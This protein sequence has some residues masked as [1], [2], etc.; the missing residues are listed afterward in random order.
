MK[1]T[2]ASEHQAAIEDIVQEHGESSRRRAEAG[3]AQV[4]CYWRTQDGDQ[5]AMAAFCRDHF[6]SDAHDCAR[7]L[8]RLETALGTT[9]G[10]LNEI[11]RDLRRWTDLRGDDMPGTDDILATFDPAPDLSEQY[12]A[13]KLAFIAMLN[14]ERPDLDTMLQ[15]GAD[16]DADRW[17]AVRVAKSFGPRIP[18]EIADEARAVGH[19]ANKWV[20]EF[21]VPVGN[22]VDEHG[23]S[24]FEP[25][26]KLLAHWLIREA[27][28]SLYG[29]P[30]GLPGQRALLHVMG[31]HID[32][33]IPRA[34]MDG[35]ASGPWDP[36]NNTIGSRQTNDFVGNTRYERWLEQFHLAQR[37][38]E[39][40]PEYP[41]ALARKFQWHRE[42]P[43]AEVESLLEQLLASPVRSQLAKLMESRLGR[44]LEAHDIYYE[45]LFESRP[46]DEM[47]ALVS[48][49][50]ADH[51]DFQAKLTTLL[52]ELGYPDEQAH[53]L[54]NNVQ[55]EIARGSGH[56][57]RP[58]MPE[59]SA[60]L[61]TSS[62]EHELGWAGF[63]T[64]MHELGHN[65]EQ[66][67]STHFVPR[68]ALRGVPNTACTEAFAFLYQSLGSQALN[69][70]PDPEAPDPFHIDSI[71]CMLA[72]CQMAGPSL[73]DI[74]TWRWLYD[75]PDADASSLRDAVLGIAAELWKDHYELYFG[76]DP[77]HVLA[78]YQHMVAH[79][80][81]L[82]DY[83]IGH[84]QSHQIR[85]CLKD[86][87]LAAETL[88]I[89]SIGRLTPDLW[90]RR[91]VSKG[92]DVEPL[93]ADTSAALEALQAK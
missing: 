1:T 54:S 68:P 64:A 56:A 31:R 65:L 46:Q 27:L 75:H 25:E 22:M 93:V 91:A 7:L 87:D 3:V 30:D 59:Y 77:A 90:M 83:V 33:S 74:R 71:Q 34:V 38:D 63:D 45:D 70:E 79:P 23:K 89:C 4:A 36:R 10:H 32:G 66:V 67:I 42:I 5:E 19:R 39:H 37:I 58:G 43:E 24:W 80:L 13:Q 29:E 69:I 26:R 60:W 82:A 18:K 21:H 50:F 9:S 73:V 15:E 48:R 55:V 53:F 78:A 51:H 61:R 14:F 20:A 16:W 92:L 35:S 41:S 40:C 76:P 86:R 17:A 72:S 57:M 12:F 85:T 81:Y 8:D 6:V 2:I 49:R 11:R 52:C 47:N 84:V 28:K 88:R 44:P 62:L